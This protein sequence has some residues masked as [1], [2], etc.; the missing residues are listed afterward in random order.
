MNVMYVCPFLAEA[1]RIHVSVAISPT[2]ISL[3]EEICVKVEKLHQPGY[4]TTGNRAPP[5]ELAA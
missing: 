5:A 3:L 1:L 4:L 2:P